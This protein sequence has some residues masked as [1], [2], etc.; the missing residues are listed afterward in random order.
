MAIAFIHMEHNKLIFTNWLRFLF[1]D[2]IQL[3]RVNL[4]KKLVYFLLAS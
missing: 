3:I 1:I 2:V 4:K